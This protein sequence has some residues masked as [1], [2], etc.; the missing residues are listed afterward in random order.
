MASRAE[1]LSG[2]GTYRG[3]RRC[4]AAA[5]DAAAGRR[6]GDLP[7]PVCSLPPPLPPASNCCLAGGLTWRE[8][9]PRWVSSSTG[10]KAPTCCAA[11]PAPPPLP[12]APGKA[13]EEAEEAIG[14]RCSDAAEPRQRRHRFRR[15]PG[16][17]E[18]RRK[19][20]LGCDAATRQSLLL[21]FVQ[22]ATLPIALP[23]QQSQRLP[24]ASPPTA[25]APPFQASRRRCLRCPRQT[26]AAARARG[27]AAA[28]QRLRRPGVSP[29]LRAPPTTKPGSRGVSAAPVTARSTSRSPQSDPSKPSASG[30]GCPCCGSTSGWNARWATSTPRPAPAAVAWT[31]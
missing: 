17:R 28:L 23:R 21:L 16:R 24:S 2:S 9:P 4:Q 3:G 29:T 14:L 11:S 1:D 30:A 12:P 5:N 25:V 7:K 31:N 20:P 13:G 18:R 15:P 8:W 27:R 19:R 22:R 26:R 6:T 10:S